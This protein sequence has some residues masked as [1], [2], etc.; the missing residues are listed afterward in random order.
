MRS[1]EH[2]SKNYDANP[3]CMF[4]QIFLRL[5][6]DQECATLERNRRLAEALQIDS[7]S[8]PFNVRS[9]SIYSDSLKDDA[10]SGF[11]ANIISENCHCLGISYYASC[12]GFFVCFF[13]FLCGLSSQLKTFLSALCFLFSEKI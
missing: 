5:E 9:T 12:L 8:D 3:E 7:S 10:R 6:C 11:N 2:P 4:I 13:Y 1:E